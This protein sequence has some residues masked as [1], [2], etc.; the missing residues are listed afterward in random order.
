MYDLIKNKYEL[1]KQNG[2]IDRTFVLKLKS[3]IIT[4][5]NK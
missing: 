4:F 1:I 2:N 5:F 3:Y